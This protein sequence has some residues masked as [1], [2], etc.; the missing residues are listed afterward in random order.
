MSEAEGLVLFD[1]DGTFIDQ[2]LTILECLNQVLKEYGTY[3]TLEELT[4]LIGTP[5]KDIIKR[6]LGSESL[7]QRLRERYKEIYIK[8]YLKNT[9]IHKGLVELCKEL[10]SRKVKLGIITSKYGSITRRFLED[11]KI[12]ELF[13]IV[14]GEGDAELKPSP[15]P[16]LYACK[17]L[18][19]SP[20][21]CIVI[22]DTVQDI[23]CGKRANC[24]TI[25][26]L[27]GYGKKGELIKAKPDYVVSSQKELRKIV[28]NIFAKNKI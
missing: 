6:K 24:T 27:W 25:A 28:Q 20:K 9:K 16:V 5:L 26:V 22:G 10:R 18:K 4:P 15:A 7:A 3:Y 12:S 11:L 8:N 17:A 14:V 21:D 1:L 19:V 23:I 13:D 2:R